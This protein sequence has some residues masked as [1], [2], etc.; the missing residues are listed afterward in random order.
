MP[1]CSATSRCR[2]AREASADDIV[3][4]AQRIDLKAR[5]VK[6]LDAKRLTTIP[7]PAIVKLRGGGFQV[8]GGRLVTGKY[9]LVD[10]V[11][12]IDRAN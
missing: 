12:K 6:R 7:V 10:P 9:R 8:F 5:V 4:A 2:E 3:R 11:T 1:I